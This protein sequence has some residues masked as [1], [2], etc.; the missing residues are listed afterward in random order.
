M[1]EG[2]PLYNERLATEF[3]QFDLAKA[4][5]ALDKVVPKKDSEGYRL[6]ASGRRV[7][8]M[9]ETDQ[10]RQA[11]VDMLQLAMPMFQAV[12]I[13]GQLRLMDRSLWETRIRQDMDYDATTNRF[14]GGGG[15]A[16]MLDPRYFVPFNDNAFYAPGWQI[17]YRRQEGGQ[18]CRAAAAGAGCAEAL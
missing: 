13:D 12:G 6:D 10:N 16:A 3:T 11:I 5:E 4:N 14:G 7:T 9:F 18:R 2:D 17:W 1:R 8:I 15:L